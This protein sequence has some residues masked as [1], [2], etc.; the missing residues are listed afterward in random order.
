MDSRELRRVDGRL[1]RLGGRVVLGARGEV[2]LVVIIDQLDQ[3][4]QLEL[5][6]IYLDC[7]FQLELGPTELLQQRV[8]LQ[9]LV[10][11]VVRGIV[12]KAIR[13]SRT[14][15]LGRAEWQ[16]LGAGVTVLT[17]EP[18]R[19]AAAALEVRQELSDIDVACSRFR[20][21]SEIEVANRSSGHQ[22]AVGPLL[23]EAIDVALRAA[24]LTDG[25]VDPTVGEAM[26]LIG[27][28]RD[29][30]SIKAG[31]P[32]VMHVVPVRGWTAVRF[33]RRW[34]T[35]HVPVGIKLDLGATAKALAADR[36]ARRAH[37]STGSGI[38]V[39]LGGDIAVAG[40]APDSGW[41]I[42]ITDWHGS[43]PTVPGPSV[44]IRA[45][46]LATSSTTVRRWN[47]GDET[48]H[49][50]IDPSTG[51]PARPV[52][53]TVTVAAASCVDANIA[54]TAAIVKGETAAGWLAS[55]GL[56][57]RLVR[58]DSTETLIGGWPL[59]RSAA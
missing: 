38:L 20:P 29:F 33:N 2:D 7:R 15:T 1:L 48:M 4:D 45:G 5:R 53:K 43:P 19:I 30:A 52:W 31:G 32:P 16:A 51:R 57:A 34:G 11:R 8:F 3:L 23:A 22:V 59:E 46:G 47:R 21:D 14:G 17:S 54:S 28:D 36:A 42:K 50:I 13:I 27:Y 25:A 12:M 55:T 40:E 24:R 44:S 26:E 37:E 9:R 49:H 6:I 56:T 41:N 35:L 18:H 39:S 58:P 10:P